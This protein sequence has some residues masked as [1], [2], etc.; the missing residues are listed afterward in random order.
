MF[1]NRLKQLRTENGLTQQDLADILKVSPSTI[2]M[3]EQ[4]RRDPDTNTIKSLAVHFSVSTDWL[5][6]LTDV[7]NVHSVI[8]I[9]EEAKQAEEIIKID[10][11]LFVQM[12]KATYLPEE[13][14]K[15]IRE[16]S[17]MLLEKHLREEKGKCKKGND[18]P[19]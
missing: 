10:S 1:G 9:R 14:R 7:P 18:I 16:Y 15:K 6:G 3:Y 8:K 4:N 19:E 12:C 5:L 11:D 17:A 13:D 2:G